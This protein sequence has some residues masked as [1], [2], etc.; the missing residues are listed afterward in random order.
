M[1]MMMMMMEME[2]EREWKILVVKCSPSEGS[3]AKDFSLGLCSNDVRHVVI[4]SSSSSSSSSMAP[5]EG[6]LP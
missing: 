5:E 2:M 6:E 4:P 1:M 3:Q